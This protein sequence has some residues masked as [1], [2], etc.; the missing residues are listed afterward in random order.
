MLG[1]PRLR[2]G[3]LLRRL[4][5]RRQDAAVLHQGPGHPTHLHRNLLHSLQRLLVVVLLSLW[6]VLGNY[7]S[8]LF[9]N[10]GMGPWGMLVFVQVKGLPFNRYSWLVTHNSFSIVGEPS[11]TGV[12]RVTFY[13]QEDTVTNQLRVSTLN[14]WANWRVICWRFYRMGVLVSFFFVSSI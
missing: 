13:N 1:G 9:F 7:S 8:L 5:R 12:E 2:G 4:R 3:P 14:I 10:H 11:R 6:L